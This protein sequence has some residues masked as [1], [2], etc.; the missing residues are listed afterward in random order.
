MSIKQ[1]ASVVE[2][3]E[4]EFPDLSIARAVV[5]GTGAYWPKIKDNSVT[6]EELARDVVYMLNTS[7]FNSSTMLA[8]TALLAARALGWLPSPK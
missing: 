8:A 1:Y 2:C 3:F 7:H 5:D 6:N 4:E